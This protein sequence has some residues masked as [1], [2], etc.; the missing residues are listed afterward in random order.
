MSLT[1]FFAAL[2]VMIAIA[3]PIGVVFGGISILPVLA[4][5]AF[6][7]T[8][9]AAV[10]SMLNGLNSFPILAIPLFML[11]GVIM[12]KG[13][14]SKRLFNFFAYFIGNKTAGFPCAAIITCLF[15]GAISG[16]GPAT[17]AA[18][19][20]MAIPFLT[21]M[22]YDLVFASAIVAVAGGL[23]VIIPPSIPFIVYSS[24]SNT[25]TS[26]LFIAGIL[27]GALI[28]LGLMVVAWV[29][30]K[31]H[32]EDKARLQ[33]NYET[34]RAQGFGRLLRES[35]WA[36]LT[37]VIILGSIYG[38]IASPTEAA[39]ISI[40]YALF[41]SLFVYKSMT[42][43]DL[44]PMLRE[45]VKTY[46]A[47]IFIIATATTFGRVVSLLQVSGAISEGV[48]SLVSGRVGVLLIINVILLAAGMLMD[49]LVSIMI[50]TPI[51]LPLAQ[52]V[53]INPIHLG[54]LMVCNL[55]VGFVT[56]PM[57]M[58]LFVTSNMTG[59][60]AMSI[61][62]KAAPFIAAFL[63]CLL[64]INFV[65]QISLLLVGT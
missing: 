33:E 8:V 10:R 58:N 65:P 12:A 42:W 9:D 28:A 52:T 18:V 36:L 24:M 14:I 49:P 61:A 54:I 23:G 55:A 64:L 57:G 30:C 19:G 43:R 31:R 20:A 7:F 40:F 60:P 6:P 62:K 59:V 44:L 51:L 38:G 47:I 11:S 1:V 27:P 32:G 41:V 16:S 13:G 2:L 21:G 4:N 35:S 56:P 63:V 48:L 26:A 3:I 34:I 45:G 50:L 22:G 39:G 5:P 53:G 37:P 25:S 29:Y 17:T 46:A 15:Y